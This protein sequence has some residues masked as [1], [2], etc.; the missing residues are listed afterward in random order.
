[1]TMQILALR[2]PIRNRGPVNHESC[3][4]ELNTALV[5]WLLERDI[6]MTNGCPREEAYARLLPYNFAV[7]E[8]NGGINAREDFHIA[9]LQR[10]TW[11]IYFA[12]CLL[13]CKTMNRDR[14]QV[15]LTGCSSRQVHLFYHRL[16]LLN[17]VT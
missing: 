6:S 11:N 14:A 8:A 4:S 15:S 2:L 12:S 9:K 5:W 17:I 7:S 1:M 3:N 10:L 16:A 13:Q